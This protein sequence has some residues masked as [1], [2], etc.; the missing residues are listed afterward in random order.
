MKDCNLSIPGLIQDPADDMQLLFAELRKRCGRGMRLPSS[1][2]IRVFHGLGRMVLH[3]RVRINH[4]EQVLLHSIRKRSGNSA[5]RT[6]VPAA[7]QQ[8]RL[9]DSKV[10][11]LIAFLRDLSAAATICFSGGWKYSGYY[12]KTSTGR[13]FLL[14]GVPRFGVVGIALFVFLYFSF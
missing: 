13:C 11:T 7:S 3:G 5:F 2:F 4:D 14:L 1:S 6:V 12:S 9:V 10:R 8:P